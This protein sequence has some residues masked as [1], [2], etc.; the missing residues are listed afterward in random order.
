MPISQVRSLESPAKSPRARHALRNASCTLY[1]FLSNAPSADPRH[2][3]S[4]KHIAVLIDPRLRIECS[5][6][7]QLTSS[8][9]AGHQPQASA[10]N[11]PMLPTTRQR[12]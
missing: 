5:R 1:Q 6:I 11:R 2:R 12:P 4:E 3:E 7:L 10:A 8:Q 9:G